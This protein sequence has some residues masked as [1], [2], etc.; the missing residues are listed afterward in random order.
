[1]LEFHETIY[2]QIKW[3]IQL[4]KLYYCFLELYIL[5]YDH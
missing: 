2:I 4:T 3:I 1:M 5:M